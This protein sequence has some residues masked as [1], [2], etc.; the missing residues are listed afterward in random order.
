V[1]RAIKQLKT[2]GWL[3]QQGKRYVIPNEAD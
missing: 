1:T 3:A 2:S